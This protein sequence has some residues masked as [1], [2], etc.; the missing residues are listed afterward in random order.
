MQIWKF[1]V[2]S[3]CEI[4]MPA[5]AEIVEVGA[6]NNDICIWAVVDPWAHTVT[7]QFDVIGTGHEFRDVPQHTLKYLGTAHLET[8]GWVFHVFEKVASA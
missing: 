7:R 2:Q 5:D 4:D 3:N 1:F 6:Q 8:D